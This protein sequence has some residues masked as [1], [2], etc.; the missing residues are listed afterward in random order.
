[1]FF[2]DSTKESALKHLRNASP[3]VK[4]IVTTLLTDAILEGNLPE[5]HKIEVRILKAHRELRDLLND[6]FDNFAQP[7]PPT[8][9]GNALCKDLYP[10]RKEFLEY[11]QAAKVGL[12]SFLRSHP[13]PV[14]TEEFLKEQ[15]EILEKEN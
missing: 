5:E 4:N 1:M 9:V 13:A 7:I 2:T 3:E 6:S 15:I 8:E 12:E 10:L 14:I 11:L